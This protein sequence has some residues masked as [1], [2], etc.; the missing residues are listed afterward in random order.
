MSLNARLSVDINSEDFEQELVRVLETKMRHMAQGAVKEFID[1][2][3]ESHMQQYVE[4]AIASK[5]D[6]LPYS[7]AQRLSDFVASKVRIALTEIDIRALINNAI[8]A[9]IDALDIQYLIKQ[10]ISELSATIA[11][12]PIKDALQDVFKCTEKGE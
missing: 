4:S 1:K 11:V 2:S 9:K 5:F 8:Q 3:F 12:E 10:K 6:K 7:V